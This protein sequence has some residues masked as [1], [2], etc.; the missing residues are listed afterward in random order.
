MSQ[1]NGLTPVVFS[2]QFETKQLNIEADKDNTF[3]DATHKQI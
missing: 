1:K 3:Y 2:G